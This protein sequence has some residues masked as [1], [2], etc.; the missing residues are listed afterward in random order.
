MGQKKE[1]RII[2]G[3]DGRESLN[4]PKGEG[5]MRER[6]SGQGRIIGEKD[7][8]K[9]VKRPKGEGE[10]RERESGQ[11]KRGRVGKKDTD[12]RERREKIC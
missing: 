5:E 12:G 8:R 2:G 9:S 6:E 4:R 3:K 7:G 11:G 1:G 10:M